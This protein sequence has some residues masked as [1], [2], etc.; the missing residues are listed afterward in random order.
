MEEFNYNDALEEL[1]KIANKIE[2][3]SIPLDQ[4]ASYIERG[5][6]LVASCKEYLRSLSG[7]LEE[8]T[9]NESKEDL[10]D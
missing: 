6:V 2:D 4:I 5:N 1:E 7:K 10:R 8:L 9:G 3:T